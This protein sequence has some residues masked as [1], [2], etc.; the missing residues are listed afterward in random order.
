MVEELS[1]FKTICLCIT[2]R[3]FTVPRYCKRLVIP[4]LSMESACDIFYAVYDCG[5]R[6]GIINYLLRQLDFHALS[7]TL[8][9]TTASHNMWDHDR[10]ARE[11]DTHRTRVLRADCSESLA[12]TIELSLAS[13]MFQNLG[14]DARDLLGVIAFFPQGVDENNVNRLFPDISNRTNI[15]DKFCTLSLTHR[16][17]R[18]ITMLAP[19]RDYLTPKDPKSSPLLCTVKNCYF[20]QLSDDVNPDKPGCEE[21]LWVMSEDVNIEHLLDVFTS[22]DANL[23]VV[24]DACASFMARLYW[25]KT[26]PV[27]LGPKIEGLPDDHPS[28]PGCLFELSRL[29]DSVGN[30]VESKRLLIHALELRRERGDRLEVART[31]VFLAM[32]S[33]HL[34]LHKEG[35]PLAREALGIYE[36]SN[37]AVGQAQAWQRLARLLY[38]DSQLDAAEEAA[39][40]SIDL[41][42]DE[43]QQFW[44]CQSH[45][46]L[47]EICHS[48]GKTE[49]AI[50]NFETAIGIASSF[51][52]HDQLS[53]SHYSLA[54]L[55]FDEH[56]PDDAHAHAEHSKSHAISYPYLLGHAIHLQARFWYDQH[57]LE[58]AKS[59]ALRAAEVYER[60]GATKDAED[61]RGILRDVETKMEKSVTPG[62][63]DF[64]GE[65]LEIMQRLTLVD[66]ILST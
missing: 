20:R 36:Q 23:V 32:T 38:C 21:A 51:D 13:P 15:L 52:W 41:L 29:F 30:F 59:E 26:R 56:R 57:K 50:N 8:L 11:W 1:Q 28:K 10:L 53:R 66:S 25:H 62:E 2:S 12:A 55:F 47:A 27:V 14:P 19:L 34:G 24:W 65:F 31:M 63:L 64:N 22:V 5:G 54:A 46:I 37:H 39:S 33:W 40:R 17:N 6:S 44:L 45:R 9:A 43:G 61:C 60:I 48:K 35:I 49:K 16:N 18:F 4:T 7:I 58:E 3:I 42:Q